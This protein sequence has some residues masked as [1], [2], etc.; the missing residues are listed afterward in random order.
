MRTGVNSGTDICV[1]LLD[2]TGEHVVHMRTTVNN[3]ELHGP[4]GKGNLHSEVKYALSQGLVVGNVTSGT[5]VFIYVKDLDYG[6]IDQRPVLI[7]PS[8]P[9]RVCPVLRACH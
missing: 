2:E 6:L 4:A 9:G 3:Q 8:F 7:P 5:V 1:D